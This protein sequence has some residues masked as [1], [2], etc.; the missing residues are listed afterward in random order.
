MA[1]AFLVHLL[2]AYLFANGGQTVSLRWLTLF[3]DFVDARR[4]NWGQACL[5]YLYCNFD[6]FSQG[7]LR[8]LVRPQKLLEV[9]FLSISYIFICSLWSCKLYH[10]ASCH[11]ANRAILY[12]TNG[13]CFL[14][15]RWIGRYGLITLGI[16]L[17]LR[18]FPRARAH[19]AGLTSDKVSLRVLVFKLLHPFPLGYSSSNLVSLQV[20]WAPWVGQ[21]LPTSPNLETIAIIALKINQPFKRV[22]LRALQSSRRGCCVNYQV[23]MTHRF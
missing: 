20:N 15:Q 7:T 8:Q 10:L 5:V 19:L 11:L 17:S 23:E 14:L 1:K 2:G 12:L 6:T 4:A 21:A 3:Q 18:E 16:D 13:L 22:N 9:S